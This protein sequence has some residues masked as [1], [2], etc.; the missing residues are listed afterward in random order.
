MPLFVSGRQRRWDD[1]RFAAY[2]YG[3][4]LSDVHGALR[5]AHTGTLAGMY[6][7]V[8]LLP[9]RGAGFVFMI[10]GEGSSAR[11]VL[12]QTLVETLLG[13]SR[14]SVASYADELE[15]DRRS[16][17]ST[18]NQLQA[19]MP[20]DSDS[21]R[22]VLGVY[23]D[24]WFGEVSLCPRDGSVQFVAAKSPR[25]AGTLMQVADRV[26][27]DWHD[28]SVDVDAWLDFSTDQGT[29]VMSM[30]KV[31]PEADFSFDF[32]DLRFVKTAACP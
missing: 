16:A 27:V 32:E 2:G 19:G 15:A 28:E 14:R 24:P 6:S 29:P 13:I 23:R 31:D 4:R 25:L 26:L 22:E 1:S 18:Q 30:T 5:V 3:W 8:T 12:N 9:E 11:V 17:P 10:N 21:V 20:V 7:A